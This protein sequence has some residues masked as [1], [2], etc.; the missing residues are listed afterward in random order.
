MGDSRGRW[1]G[2]TLIVET[3][4]F[5]PNVPIGETFASDALPLVERFTRTDVDTLQYQVM[6][7]DPKT[8]TRSWTISFPLKR[9]P[10]YRL[11][12]YACHEGNYDIANAL[13]GG[14][15]ACTRAYIRI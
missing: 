5:L 7:D 9:D 12:E 6:I 10:G 15:S 14:R 2:G 1:D 13:R 4:N 11:F 3:T 8:W